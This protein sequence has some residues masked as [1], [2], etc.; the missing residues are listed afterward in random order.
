MRFFHSLISPST[1]FH[2]GVP[3]IVSCFLTMILLLTI[4]AIDL[5]IS[6]SLLVAFP[7]SSVV[8]IALQRN[9]KETLKECRILGTELNAGIALRRKKVIGGCFSKGCGYQP[10]SP[11]I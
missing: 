4:A 9:N 3:G 5:P 1:G 10:T 8:P 11:R 6:Q 2:S 7:D